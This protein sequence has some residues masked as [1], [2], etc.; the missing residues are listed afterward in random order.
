MLELDY[1]LTLQARFPAPSWLPA[2][3][4][5]VAGAGLFAQF[6]LIV[7]GTKRRWLFNRFA[8]ERLRC[9]KFEAFALIGRAAAEP[10]RLPDDVVAFTREAL[11]AL[12][13]ELMGGWTALVD[14]APSEEL[15]K[16]PQ[17]PAEYDREFVAEA[18][19]VYDRLRLGVQLQ[20]FEG[21]AIVDTEQDRLPQT[22]GEAAFAAGALIALL[23]IVVA[24]TGLF[25]SFREG[26]PA[27]VLHFFAWALFAVSAVIAIYQRGAGNGPSAERY[28]R[29][30]REI[31]RVRADAP[32]SDLAL[33]LS[34]VAEMEKIALRELHDFCR[35]AARLSYVL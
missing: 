10:A 32:H 16:P 33:F 6:L 1:E 2:L 18:A 24:T 26:A 23:S 14:F 31:R 4:A 7:T 17:P 9:L 11:S 20:H 5:I 27:A 29:Y 34:T 19:V 13:L 21:R 8:A 28:S 15:M 35:D 22:L 3:T 30:V 25:P 12:E